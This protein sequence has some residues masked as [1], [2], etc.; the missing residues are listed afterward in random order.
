MRSLSRQS[1]ARMVAMHLPQSGFV[2]LGIGAP[3]AV[4]DY[5]PV[6]SNVMLHSENGILNVGPKPAE[7][8][9]DWD[10]INAGKMPITIAR[11]G[12][13]FD[14][15]TSFSMM[16]GGHLDIA[17][18]GAFEVS[19]SGDLA[20]WSTGEGRG[21]GIPPAVGGAIDLAVG[22]DSIWVMMDHITKAGAPRIVEQCSLPLT[23]KGVVKRI[24]TNFAIIDVGPDGLFVD[25]IIEGL[26]FTTLQSM[27]GAQLQQRPIVRLIAEDGSVSGGL[28]R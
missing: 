21:N 22:A 13:F 14:S 8:Q 28:A 11:G 24:F 26:T 20:N 9:E 18:L 25:A 1:L 3:T 23:A 7:G 16:R 17:V 15:S 6:E 4:A 27:T 10:L 12:S 2:N 5:L 19:L